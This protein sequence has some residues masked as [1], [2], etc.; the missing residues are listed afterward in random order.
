MTVFVDT[1]QLS[2]K[3]NTDIIDITGT[4]NSFVKDSKINNG[5]VNVCVQHSTCGITT[6]ENESGLISDFK[7]N[8]EKLVPAKGN[9]AHNRGFEDNA[10]SHIRA[11]IVGSSFSAPIKNG[12]LLLGTW[13]QIVLCDFDTRARTRTVNIVITGE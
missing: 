3:G 6:I 13:Q 8:L 9:Y 5:I 10:H 4:V 12:S 11:S 2:T 7:N 1:F